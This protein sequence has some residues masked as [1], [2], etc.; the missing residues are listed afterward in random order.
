M[1][2]EKDLRRAFLVG[3]EGLVGRG[4]GEEEGEGER[5]R[6][7]VDGVGEGVERRLEVWARFRREVGFVVGGVRGIGSG[8]VLVVVGEEEGKERGWEE[9]REPAV[10]E[11]CMPAELAPEAPLLGRALTFPRGEGA[12]GELLPT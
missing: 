6:L 12:A 4:E 1:A 9:G 3:A 11:R 5:A 10:R 7:V 2:A 8:G